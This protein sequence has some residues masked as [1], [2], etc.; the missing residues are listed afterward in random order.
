M[1]GDVAGVGNAASPRTQAGLLAAMLAPLIGG[2]LAGALN[3]PFM[4]I[5]SGLIGVISLATLH[6]AVREPRIKNAPF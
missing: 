1:A 6:F 4:F 5:V 3:Y 2:W